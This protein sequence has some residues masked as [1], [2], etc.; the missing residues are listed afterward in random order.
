MPSAAVKARLDIVPQKI[1]IENRERGGELTILNLFNKK[2]T[3]RIEL[4]NFAQNENGVY[5]QLN[6]PL[7]PDFD[8]ATAVRISPRQFSLE[9]NGRQKIRMSIRRPADL[10]EGEYRFHVKAIRLAQDDERRNAGDG[11][12]V[13][14]N[15]GV[16]IPV[17]VRHGNTSAS[18]TLNDPQ[19]VE[20]ARTKSGKPELHLTVNR[21][22]N[23]STIGKLEVIWQPQGGQNRKIGQMT[24]LNVFTDIEKRLIK[25][26]LYEMPLGQG[27]I[28]V[29]YTD[30]K[31]GSKIIDEKTLQR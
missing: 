30:A 18:A 16:T 6:A 23:A 8:P 22:G 2:G 15:V 4:V 25:L 24:N 7:S 5:Q 11:I 20:A 29:R 17:I 27:Q 14:A 19:I 1:I 3:F 31:D 26:P 12:N 13:L 21:E 28:L 10:P 9:A